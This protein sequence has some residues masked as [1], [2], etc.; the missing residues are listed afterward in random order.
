M[1]TNQM[2]WQ[3]ES[4]ETCVEEDEE[5]GQWNLD[6]FRNIEKNQVTNLSK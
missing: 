4:S 2:F 5:E 6:L 1:D 3:M